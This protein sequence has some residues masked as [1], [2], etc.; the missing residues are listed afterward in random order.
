M[1]D[2][3]ETLSQKLYRE[4]VVPSNDSPE[5]LEDKQHGSESKTDNWNSSEAETRFYSEAEIK[6]TPAWLWIKKQITETL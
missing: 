3:T 2:N 6:L 4:L 5:T 1:T